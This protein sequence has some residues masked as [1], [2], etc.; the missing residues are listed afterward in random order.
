MNMSAR[1][2]ELL[3]GIYELGDPRSTQ[4]NLPME[5]LRGLAVTL[6]FFVHYHALF[7]VWADPGSLTFAVSDFLGT[8]GLAGVDLFF[9]LSGY[10]IYGLIFKKPT[11]YASF[12]KRRIQRIY[13]TFLFVLA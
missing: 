6:V 13:P 8:V 9:V 5:G 12:I 1:L 11:R 4:R 2:R 7:K 3:A 10:L